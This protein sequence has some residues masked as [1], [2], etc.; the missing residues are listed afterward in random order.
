[1]H[2]KFQKK[3]EDVTQFKKLMPLFRQHN[4]WSKYTIGKNLYSFQRGIFLHFLSK[5]QIDPFKIE[6]LWPMQ[7]MFSLIGMNHSIF[8]YKM[9][10]MKKSI[11]QTIKIEITYEVIFWT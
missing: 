3:M 7:Q 6:F 2:A 4:F 8:R 10:V 11:L 5:F 1:M 9:K